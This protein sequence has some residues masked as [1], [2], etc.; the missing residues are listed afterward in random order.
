VVADIP[1][2]RVRVKLRRIQCE[3]RFSALPSNSDITRYCPMKLA[4]RICAISGSAFVQNP[5]A[6]V[7]D[8]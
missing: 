8:V 1:G 6:R 4:L 5:F 3:Q 7:I 2:L